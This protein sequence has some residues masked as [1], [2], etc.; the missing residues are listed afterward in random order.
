MRRSHKFDT[1]FEPEPITAQLLPQVTLQ[2]EEAL[3][4]SAAMY[5]LSPAQAQSMRRVYLGHIMAL[6]EEI[7]RLKARLGD[8]AAGD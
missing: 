2:Q 5:P 7:Q 6:S 4:L 1:P 3:A 8:D